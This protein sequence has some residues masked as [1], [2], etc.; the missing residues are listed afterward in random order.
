MT[1]KILAGNAKIIA[2]PI[3]NRKYVHKLF[4]IYNIKES[5][6][7]RT[8]GHWTILSAVF[9]PASAFL[10]LSAELIPDILRRRLWRDNQAFQLRIL[11]RAQDFAE[12]WARLIAHF[13]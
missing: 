4:K 8:A 12:S 13:Q 9:L 10:L 5:H 1:H 7:N 2:T 3:P 11:D 6:F